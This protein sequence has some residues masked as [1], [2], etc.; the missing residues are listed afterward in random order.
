VSYPR[1]MVPH[2]LIH[3]KGARG[4]HPRASQRRNGPLD[5]VR[6]ARSAGHLKTEILL[7]VNGAIRLYLTSFSISVLKLLGAANT[8]PGRRPSCGRGM[9]FAVVRDLAGK[10]RDDPSCTCRWPASS[11]CRCSSSRFPGP[12]F[13]PCSRRAAN[14]AARIAIIAMT[15]NSS[16]SVNPPT[17]LRLGA[18]GGR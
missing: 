12:W 11:V 4:G 6:S 14:I 9:V 1:Q 2:R 10:G 18:G 8:R 3:C 5:K 13:S 15:T 7:P 16:I 17:A